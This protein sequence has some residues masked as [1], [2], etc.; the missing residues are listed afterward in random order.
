MDLE[1]KNDM[2]ALG[3]PGNPVSVANE[4]LRWDPPLKK[5]Y[6]SP[7]GE[8]HTGGWF[9]SKWIPKLWSLENLLISQ[10]KS[11]RTTDCCG[12]QWVW[13]QGIGRDTPKSGGGTTDIQWNHLPFERPE[14]HWTFTRAPLRKKSGKKTFDLVQFQTDSDIV[15]A[16]QTAPP[17]K[18]VQFQQSTSHILFDEQSKTAS[19]CILYLHL[20]QRINSTEQVPRT[21]VLPGSFYD[22][23]P[24]FMHYYSW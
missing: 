17:K 22:T 4:G 1:V 15:L 3:L 6:N 13:K 24:N 7:A 14:S 12:A 23:N 16:P 18:K 19:F 21:R 9:R 8:W 5:I 20:F 2:D 11:L 10:M